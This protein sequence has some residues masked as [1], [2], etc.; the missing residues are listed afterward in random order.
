MADDDVS[1]ATLPS[2]EARGTGPG[3]AAQPGD[4]GLRP[5]LDR[6]QL[7]GTLARHFARGRWGCW[8]STEAAGWATCAGRSGSRHVFPPRPGWLPVA[9][10]VAVEDGSPTTRR[11][12][13]S[14]PSSSLAHRRQP[15]G[16]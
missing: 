1:I 3:G 10:V 16:P 7:P 9:A 2:G 14:Q 15:A 5:L 12:R 4:R 11:V 8:S 6:A 13:A